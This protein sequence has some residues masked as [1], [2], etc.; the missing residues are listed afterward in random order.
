MTM[1]GIMEGTDMKVADTDG[2]MLTYAAATSTITIFIVGILYVI[3]KR[4]ARVS[5]AATE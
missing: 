3:A 4:M 1:E 2:G 5:D